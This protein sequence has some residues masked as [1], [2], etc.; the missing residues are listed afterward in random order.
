MPEPAVNRILS[1]EEL[2]NMGDMGPCELVDGRII[3]LSPTGGEH[4]TIEGNIAYLLNSYIRPRSLG[5]VLTG[6][7]GIY[8]RHDPDRVRA[9]DVAFV[10]KNQIDTIPSGFL[11][12]PP[13]LVV[14]V[15]SPSDR[16]QDLR[17]KMDEYFLIGVQTLWIVEPKT[18]TIMVYSSPTTA[19]KY[20]KAETV[21]ASETLT[22]LEVSVSEI[23]RNVTTKDLT[24]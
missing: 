19:T 1:G 9:A 11:D 15:V 16:W 13:E 17:D 14:E 3:P 5:W 8:T 6:E 20:D 18:R 21:A 24:P 4:G 12:I 23:F 10:A 2:L 7:V 22:G